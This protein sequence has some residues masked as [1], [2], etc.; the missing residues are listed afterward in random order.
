MYRR[1]ARPLTR[2]SPTHRP[3]AKLWRWLPFVL[4]IGAIAGSY[5]SG[6]HNYLSLPAIAEHRAILKDMVA[7]HL[8]LALGAYALVYVATVALLLPGAVILSI[9]GG[10][11]FGWKVSAPVTILSATLGATI[12]FETVKISLGGVIA[13]RAGPF[14]E[15]LRNGFS[16]N[17]F[18]YL[19]FLR[20]V[21]LF[22]F[23]AVNAV[24][25]L[26]HIRLST[27][28]LA[29]LTGIIPATLIYSYLGSGF[30]ALLDE[31]MRR[32]RDCV[33]Q[34]GE[35]SC[36]PEFDVFSLLTPEMIAALV[37]LALLALVPIAAQRITRRSEQKS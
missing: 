23:F 34:A 31:E 25:G 29:T 16:R 14:V 21:P 19:L 15:R 22:P 6:L 8:I 36:R 24:A 11:L 12:V 18:S 4:L 3:S 9:L 32:W 30:D 10:F 17:G 27:F 20:L 2:R 5:A 7:K 35:A 37:L 33:A 13:K 26:V 28:V 1:M